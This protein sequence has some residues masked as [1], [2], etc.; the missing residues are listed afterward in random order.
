MKK[1]MIIEKNDNSRDT[2]NSIIPTTMLQYVEK[3][4]YTKLIRNQ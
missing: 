3:T 2:K 4:N 1:E